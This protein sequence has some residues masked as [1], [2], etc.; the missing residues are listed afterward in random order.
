[1]LIDIVLPPPKNLS[2]KIGKLA[3]TIGKKYRLKKVV[4]GKNLLPH[5]TLLLLAIKAERYRQNCG[6]SF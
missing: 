6:R 2:D 5:C 3:A 1:V 4:D